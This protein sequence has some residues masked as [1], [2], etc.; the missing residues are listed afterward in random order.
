[1][2]SSTAIDLSENLRRRIHFS[3]GYN[4]F[5]ILPALI[6]LI[7]TASCSAGKNKTGN[8][9]NSSELNPKIERKVD[10][11]LGMMTLEEKINFLHGNGFF[12]SGGDERLGIPRLNIHRWAIR[13][14]GRVASEFMGTS[15]PHE[16]FSYFFPYRVGTGSYL[17]YGPCTRIWHSNWSGSQGQG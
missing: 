15:W 13:Y 6:F 11:L 9:R 12:T 3:V 16:R 14:Q 2:E 4:A 8:D 17:E 7:A 1:M 10:S 5:I